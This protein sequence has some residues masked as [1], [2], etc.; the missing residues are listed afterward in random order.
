MPADTTTTNDPARSLRRR[1]LILIGVLGVVLLAGAVI[2][3]RE[4]STSSSA[5][6]AQLQARNQVLEHSRAIR[7][8]VFEGYKS[9][10][11]FLLDPTRSEH[12]PKVAEWLDQAISNSE[13]LLSDAWIAEHRQV[14][15]VRR[16]KQAT[17]ALRS[18][19]GQL[20]ETRLEPTRQYPALAAANELMRPNRNAFNNAMALALRETGQLAQQDDSAREVLRQLFQARHLWTQM[21]SNFRL[22]LAN[23]VG[24]FDEASLPMQE[25][26]I[27]L[28]R[29][30]LHSRLQELSGLD[31]EGRLGFETAMALEQMTRNLAAYSEGLAR[32]N[33]IHASGE[34]RADS[35][36]I[37]DAIEPDLNLVAMLLNTVEQALADSASQD[38]SLLTETITLQTRFAWLISLL[39]LV[40]VAV[41]VLSL[42]LLVF[43]PIRSVAEGLKAEAFGEEGRPVPSAG[44][45]ETQAL[46]DAFS[47]MRNQVHQRQADLQHQAYHDSLTN[48]PNR[49]L[50]QDR[51]EQAIHIARRQHTPFA[52]L[53]LDLDRFKDVNDTLGH[54]VGDQLLAEVGR[55]L[56]DTLRE[57]DTIARLGGDEFAILLM[58]SD[59]AT[60]QRIAHKITQTLNSPFD[61]NSLRLYTGA[62]IGIACYPD[63][64][65]DVTTLIQRA[66][67]A[68]YVAKRDQSN[69]ALY[70]LDQDNYSV[71]RLALM[72]DLRQALENNELS[73]HYQPKLDVASGRVIGVEALL[74]WQHPEYGAIPPEQVVVLA[75]HTGL[76][77]P[78]TQWVMEQALA[79]AAGWRQDGLQLT[80][81]VNLSVHNLRDPAFQTRV[82]ECLALHRMPA[83][84]L[85]LEITEHAMMANPAEATRILR[86]LDDMGVMLAVDD[87]GTGFSS[88]AYLKQLPV[89]ELKIDK[90]FVM[91]M[92]ENPNDEII[93]RST[94]DLAH[95]LGLRVVAEGV[96]HEQAWRKLLAL[97]CDAAQGYHMSRPLPPDDLRDWLARQADRA[98]SGAALHRV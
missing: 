15:N 68:M 42:N 89:D 9:L 16:L 74:R 27:A 66:D 78:L 84:S 12:R 26:A 49:L 88:L 58:D 45:Q 37:K 85:T 5:S 96:E 64:G 53:M 65:L 60:A 62:S 21:V 6:A 4:L 29:E 2:G 76:I 69:H 41:I 95:N 57:V 77:G 75:E 82:G 81:A 35:K 30:E 94:I 40:F 11:A 22:Y 10:N 24:S 92:H 98:S 91:R 32:V 93:V 83:E 80:M 3:Q 72:A 97:G 34:W 51:M 70:A 71:S 52:F 90:S 86:A 36:F 25:S 17:V 87:Y 47:E 55:R 56:R 1:Y 13:R 54:H 28:L 44:Y 61:I 33:A 8:G 50:L 48:L 63:H 79:T 20:I 31:A 18:N 39:G 59:A 43:R 73:L 14:D 38:L 46:V 7:V 19:I 23:R 67:V